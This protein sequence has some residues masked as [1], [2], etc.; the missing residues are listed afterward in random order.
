MGNNRTA[1]LLAA[2][3]I[4]FPTVAAAQIDLLGVEVDV[5]VDLGEGVD[6]DAS[7]D[8]GGGDE[9]QS[10]VGLDASVEIGGGAGGG[11]GGGIDSALDSILLPGGV[12]VDTQVALG[13]PGGVNADIDALMALGGEPGSPIGSLDLDAIADIVFNRG[14]GVSGAARLGAGGGAM[15][16]NMG[17]DLDLN[18]LALGGVD[19]GLPGGGGNQGG[20]A[21]GGPGAPGAPVPGAPVMVPSGG[22]G[23]GWSPGGTAV[24]SSL[25]T[26]WASL[27]AAQQQRLVGQCL[28]ILAR[29][30][31][32]RR[33]WVDLCRHVGVLPGVQQ[34]FVAAR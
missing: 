17:I 9:G 20:P 13:G 7:L 8:V 31:D 22:A 11:N 23:G 28:T 3:F 14:S 1:L 15:N 10:L 2:I 5:S 24:P 4:S 29:P 34:V 19:P 26:L 21:P 27:N 6:V 25:L 18:L 30:R 16:P 32:F 33:D 12:G